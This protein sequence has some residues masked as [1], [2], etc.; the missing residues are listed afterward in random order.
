M[1]DSTLPSPIDP[2]SIATLRA[3]GGGDA[4][5]VVEI[6]QM[7]REDTPPNLDELDASA[8]RG[9]ANRLAKV[10]HGLKGSAANFGAR[11]FR[12]LAEHIEAI[13][14]GGALSDAPAAI[15]ALREE[16]QRV[17]TALDALPPA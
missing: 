5:F 4:T 3:I 9:D 15:A 6:V 1:S 10:A 13:A 14:K 8:A 17:I 12:T 11:R 16:Y 2:A 7:F